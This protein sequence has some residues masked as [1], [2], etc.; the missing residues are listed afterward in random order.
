LISDVGSPPVLAFVVVALTASWVSAPG[1]WTWAV[2]YLLL[3][4]LLPFLHV[5]WLVRRG[6][7][8]DLHLRVR[9]QRIQP[10]LVT[11]ASAGLGWLVLALAPAPAALTTIAAALWLQTAAI[12]TITLRWKISVHTAAAAGATTIAW[13]LLGTALPFLL[14]VPLI[15]WSRIRLG[16]HTLLQ[17]L[18]GALLGFIVFSMAAS[19]LPTG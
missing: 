3:A 7:V 13:V 6:Q 14:T 10:L 19:L 17:T 18:V 8:T 11:I 2:I 4:V 9:E 1:A 5:V 15:A 12:L 16:R